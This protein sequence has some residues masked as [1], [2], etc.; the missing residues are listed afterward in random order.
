MSSEEKKS[1]SRSGRLSWVMNSIRTQYSMATAFFLM[2]ILAV[3]YIGGRIVL[4]HLVRDTETQVKSVGMDVSRIANRNAE[5]ARKANEGLV[6]PIAEDIEGS[7]MTAKAAMEAVG[8]SAVSVIAWYAPDGRLGSAAQ[9]G[10]SGEIYEIPGEELEQYSERIVAWMKGDAVTEFPVGIILLRGTAHYVSMSKLPSGAVLVL[11]S[12][13]S[14]GEFSSQLGVGNTAYTVD[15]RGISPP[16]EGMGVRRS[17]Y[18]QM[19]STEDETARNDFGFAPMLSSALDYY[20]GGFWSIGAKPFEA[21]F[22]VRDIAGNTVTT[23]AVSLPAEFSRVTSSA[24]GRFTFFVAVIGIFLVIPVFWIQG[25][26]L[27]NPLTKMTCAIRD[28]SGHLGEADC[29]RLEWKGEDEFALLAESVN[30]MLETISER[31][32]TLG[33]LSDRQRALIKGI[34]D[35]LAVFDAKGRLVSITKQPEYVKPI[36]Y[37][38]LG[39]YMDPAVWGEDGVAAFDRALKRMFDLKKPSR[40]RLTDKSS[41]NREDWRTFE[42]RLTLL[43]EHFALAITRDMTRETREHELR[44]AAER[45]AADLSKR[46]SLTQFAAGI[47]HDVNNVLTVI[48]NTVETGMPEHPDQASVARAETIRK[49][50]KRGS[51]MTKELMTFA[52]EAKM[53]LSRLKPS[54]IVRDSQMLAEGVLG[55]NVDLTFDLSPDAPDVD[56]DPNQFWKVIFNIVKNASEA[57]GD[58]PGH[59]V[60]STERYEMTAE[61][62][63]AYRSDRPLKPGVGTMMRIADDGPGIK[64]EFLHRMFDPYVSSKSVGRGLGLATVLSIVEAHGGGIRVTSRLDEGTTFHIYLPESKLSASEE[65]VPARTE[66][67]LP[68]EVLIVDN[69]EAILKT[70]SIL[71]KTLNVKPLVAHDRAEALGAIRRRSDKIGVILLDAHLGG[72]DTVRLLGSFRVAA[73]R[74][75]VVIFSGSREADLKKMFASQPFDGFLAKP[76]TLA[77]MREAIMLGGIEASS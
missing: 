33:Q 30:R 24:L 21:V 69:D 49:A 27:L 12:P 44:I 2:L 22:A 45:Q 43:D 68:E 60:I 8:P 31:T 38:S 64:P 37:S 76:Y 35:A 74:A 53:T 63:C 62:A 48:Q 41:P 7:G 50:V 13:F 3:F 59:I 67:S 28:L 58:R 57:I 11:G 15:V 65:G 29:P 47:A 32:V 34:P 20:S 66:G 23:V 72:I 1:V 52:G 36:P 14:V 46:E 9:R 4:V 70:S 16:A 10:E 71:L 42:M 56:A 40:V 18:V 51:A 39:G 54:F 17:E 6:A 55:D 77:E 75:K 73:P 19:Y 61:R 25:K 26:V 5:R